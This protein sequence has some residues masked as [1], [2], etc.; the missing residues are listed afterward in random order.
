MPSNL[1][2]RTYV[3]LHAPMD[4]VWEAL[5]DPALIKQWFFGVDTETTWTIGSS[6]VHKGEYQGKP[7]E[8]KGVVLNFHPPTTLAYSHWSSVSGLPDSEENYQ[9]VTFS[10]FDRG[11]FTDLTVT[12]QNLPSEEAKAVSDTNWRM[13]LDSLKELLEKELMH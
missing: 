8:D 7:Y 6:I 4:K 3:N 9:N 12:E 11:D 13:V 2:T 1:R 10:L 5:T